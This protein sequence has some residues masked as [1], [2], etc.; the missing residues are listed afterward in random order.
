MFWALLAAAITAAYSSFSVWR[1][2]GMSFNERSA[3]K[4]L[5]IAGT[6]ATFT[7]GIADTLFRLWMLSHP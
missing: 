5:I 6:L 3:A 4:T 1:W 2:A 7:L